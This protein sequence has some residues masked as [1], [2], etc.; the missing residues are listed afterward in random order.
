M[1][2][3]EQTT[4]IDQISWKAPSWATRHEEHDG[5][6]RYN[7][8]PQAVPVEQPTF[9]ADDPTPVMIELYGLDYLTVVDGQVRV[10]R[11]MPEVLVGGMRLTVAET[12]R[13]REA[14]GEVLDAAMAAAKADEL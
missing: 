1:T 6:L 12:F 5:G 8:I 11:C 14:L 9:I 10:N 7:L 13:L 2:S 4:S 3:T